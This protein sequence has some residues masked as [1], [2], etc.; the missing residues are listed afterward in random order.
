VGAVFNFTL[1][2]VISRCTGPVPEEV[3]KLVDNIRIPSGVGQA[4]DH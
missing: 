3:T 1:A 4:Q 2:L